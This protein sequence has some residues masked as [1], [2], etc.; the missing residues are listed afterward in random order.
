MEKSAPLFFLSAPT[1]LLA[2][3]EAVGAIG[4][5]R[6]RQH[7]KPGI[8]QC[9]IAGQTGTAAG[10]G[11]NCFCRKAFEQAR[12]C[13]RRNRNYSRVG[14][15]DGAIIAAFQSMVVGYVHAPIRT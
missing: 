9:R 7:A 4:R 12:P 5:Q 2:P 3:S 10:G 1:F 11:G 14:R 6:V 15:R 13:R 8:G